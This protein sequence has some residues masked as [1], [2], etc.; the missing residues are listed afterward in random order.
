[1][2]L[3]RLL[4]NSFFT[5]NL[6]SSSTLGICVVTGGE[7]LGRSAILSQVLLQLPVLLAWSYTSLLRLAPVP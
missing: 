3:S 5:P 4:D 6:I 7:K 1:M 2:R